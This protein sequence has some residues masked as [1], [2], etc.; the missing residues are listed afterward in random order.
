MLICRKAASHWSVMAKASTT[1]LTILSP[2]ITGELL[3]SLVAG[4]EGVRIYTRFDVQLFASGASSIDQLAKLI[5]DDHQVFRINDLHAK[6]VMDENSFATVG[7]QNLTTRGRLHNLELTVSLA[8][9][10]AREKVKARIEP[11]LADA[12][13]ITP[14][15]IANMRERIE[16]A[17]A[18]HQ[19]FRSACVEAEAAFQE[20][21]AARETAE[22]AERIRGRRAQRERLRQVRDQIRVEFEKRIVSEATIPAKVKS[23][24]NP[25]HSA[26]LAPTHPGRFTRWLANSGEIELTTG[27]RHLCVLPNMELGWAKIAQQRITKISR[28]VVT[29]PGV[30]PFDPMLRLSLSTVPDDLQDF[31]PGANISVEVLRGKRSICIVPV[32]FNIDKLTIF[33][34]IE[35]ALPPA[36]NRG[37]THRPRIGSAIR[38]W[39]EQ[40]EDAFRTIVKAQIAEGFVYSPGYRLTGEN[41]DAFF[42]EIGTKCFVAIALD[43]DYKILSVTYPPAKPKRIPRNRSAAQTK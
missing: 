6:V 27:D 3:S 2:F 42:G 21:E 36:R 15:M 7:S 23:P 40:N 25:A 14:A 33:P 29:D 17:A 41:A 35:S 24:N 26:F 1:P 10:V 20:Q 16:C 30:L 8:G 43:G 19:A 34:S 39:I 11:W 12:D 13:P 38:G 18:L 37:S 32:S 4:K 22:A 5:A 9:K 28:S 31:P